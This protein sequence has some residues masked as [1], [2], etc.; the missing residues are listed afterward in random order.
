MVIHSPDDGEDGDQERRQTGDTV[1][2]QAHS[3]QPLR[4]VDKG[5]VQCHRI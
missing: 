3:S 2:K 1:R 4:S 5:G